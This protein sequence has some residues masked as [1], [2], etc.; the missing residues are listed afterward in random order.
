MKTRLSNGSS[1]IEFNDYLDSISG[2]L[3]I[4]IRKGSHLYKHII[5]I[6]LCDIYFSL[7]RIQTGVLVRWR[8]LTWMKWNQFLSLYLLTMN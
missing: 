7:C 4:P 1:C 2:H 5:S 6:M 8:M 3:K